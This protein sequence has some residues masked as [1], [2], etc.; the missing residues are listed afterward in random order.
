M[1]ARPVKTSFNPSAACACLFALA[2]PVA[3]GIGCSEENGS[4]PL[5]GSAALSGSA[6]PSLP[7]ASPVESNEPAGPAAALY[8]FGGPLGKAVALAD[9]QLDEHVASPERRR[10][11]RG[12]IYGSI[13]LGLIGLIASLAPRS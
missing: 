1:L 8:Q 13:L 3:I 6:A 12:V 2:V 10:W 9:S 4:T 11:I 7:G 5:A